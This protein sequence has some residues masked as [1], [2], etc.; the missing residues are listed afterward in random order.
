VPQENDGE[1]PVKEETR[2]ARATSTP[3]KWARPK[4]IHPGIAKERPEKKDFQYHPAAYFSAVRAL[5]AS[6]LSR[7]A[8]FLGHTSWECGRVQEILPKGGCGK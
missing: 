8:I 6:S 2:R 5:A 7:G 1:R 3:D 4:E